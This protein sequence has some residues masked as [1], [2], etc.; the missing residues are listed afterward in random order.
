M[1]GPYL[2]I[3]VVVLA[4]GYLSVGLALL[5]D[6]RKGIRNGELEPLPFVALL[7]IVLGWPLIG[8]GVLAKIL[9]KAW[10]RRG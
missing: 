5:A 10:S 1:I 9:R 6:A 7:F 8:T 4:V 3:G 2:A